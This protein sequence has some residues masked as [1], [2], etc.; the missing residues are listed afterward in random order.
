MASTTAAPPA[1]AAAYESAD[2]S[3]WARDKL[4]QLT[5]D[6]KI[7]LT[8]GSDI[9]RTVALPAKGVPYIKLTDGPVG[10]RGGGDFNVG[11]GVGVGEGVGADAGALLAVVCQ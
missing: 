4:Q 3:A 11:V 8:A 1:P 10:A 6:D 9:W 5:R 2:I 7:A